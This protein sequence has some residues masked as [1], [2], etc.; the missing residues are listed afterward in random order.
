MPP[1]RLLGLTFAHSEHCIVQRCSKSSLM[2]FD[3]SPPLTV[4]P[5]S[6]ATTSAVRSVPYIRPFI[7]SPLSFASCLIGSPITCL[8][9]P[10]PLGWPPPPH[11]ESAPVPHS[12]AARCSLN[13]H[14]ACLSPP[15]RPQVPPR[16]SLRVAS[17]RIS[18]STL[19][20]GNCK[21]GIGFQLA[22]FS[23]QLSGTRMQL[24]LSGTQV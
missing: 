5:P 15:S 3:C 18:T 24:Q 1:A 2:P 16:A 10:L 17:C 6:S 19:P 22:A 12:L 8:G 21:G 4:W 9:W 11:S 13:S 23:M 20:A 14:A 7:G